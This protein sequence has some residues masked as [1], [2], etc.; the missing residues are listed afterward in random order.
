MTRDGYKQQGKNKLR[1]TGTPIRPSV[2]FSA[3]TLQAR[4]EWHGII[5][6]MK[7]KHLQP[8][9]LYPTSLSFRFDGKIRSFIDKQKLKELSTT[10]PALQEMSKEFLEAKK[11]RYN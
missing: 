1:T 11:K 2:D 4:K 8:R 6:V 5:K 9:M 7:G 10:K 3:E